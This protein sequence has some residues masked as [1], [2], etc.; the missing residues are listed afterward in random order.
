MDE[1][2]NKKKRLLEIIKRDAVVTGEQKPS[3]SPQGEKNSR[4]NSWLLDFR[5]IFLDPIALELIV[6]I[7]WHQFEKEY[8]FQVGGQEVAAIPLVSAIVLHSQKIGRPVNGFFIRKSRKPT[9]LQ[10][11]IEGKLNDEK[12]ILVDDLT[13]SG[14]T[15]L[16]QARVLKYAGKK[17]SY[18]FAL[19]SFRKENEQDMTQKNI[20]LSYLYNLNEIGLTVSSQKNVFPSQ[21]FNILWH[22]QSPKP[23][24]FLRVGKSSPAL[25]EEKIYFGADNGCLWALNQNDGSVAWKFEETGYPTKEGKI[26]LSSPALYENTVF[27]GA[28]DGNLYAVNKETGRLRWK[29]MDADYIGS[30]PVVAPDL[31]LLFVGLEFGLFK[32]RGG[33]TALDLK[34]GKKTWDY[35]MTEFVHCSPAYCPE[36]KVVAIGGN[37]FYVYLFDAK[38][39][40]LKWKYRTGGDIK[41][42]LVFDVKRN[43]LIFGSFDKNVYALDIDTGEVKGKFKTKEVIYSTPLVYG[44]NVYFGSMDKHFYSVNLDSGKLNWHIDCGSRLFAQPQIIK[45]KIYI[46]GTGGIMH[47]IDPTTGK[48]TGYFITTERITNKVVYNPTTKRFFLPTYANEIYCLEKNT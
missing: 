27:F 18:A 35:R 36:K 43:F 21:K 16:R 17:P 25:D 7:F 44:D 38:T 32:K 20:H 40:G 13:N 28:Y 45:G 24:F 10:K 6:E 8:P 41:A 26:I 30:S 14:S 23:N 9:G 42:S 47:E 39:G 12:I 33:I 4:E 29:N 31:G 46:G 11:I 22:F 48:K 2:E 15:F 3:V 37:D 19:V 34:T 5:N 1:I